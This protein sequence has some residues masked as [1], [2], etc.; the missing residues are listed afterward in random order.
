MSENN[1]QGPVK[2]PTPDNNNNYQPKVLFIW[3]AIFA[4]IASLWILNPGAPDPERQ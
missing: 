1:Q 4:A 2:P 3:L